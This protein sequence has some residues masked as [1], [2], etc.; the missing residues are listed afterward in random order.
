[1][2][3]H[4]LSIYLYSLPAFE[5][6]QKSKMVSDPFGSHATVLNKYSVLQSS[7]DELPCSSYNMS[8]TDDE[9]NTR[10]KVWCY[11][12]QSAGLGTQVSDIQKI[13]KKLQTQLRSW[14]KAVG[15][16]MKTPEH[17]NATLPLEVRSASSNRSNHDRGL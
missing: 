14:R 13:K 9:T 16:A 12:V 10:E 5:F 2:G 6:E 3:L 4:Y 1:M 15:L 8:T 17:F 11:I 7:V